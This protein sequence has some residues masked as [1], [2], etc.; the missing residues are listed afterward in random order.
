MSAS[1]HYLP[2]AVAGLLGAAVAG[3]A[4]TPARAQAEKLPV[5]CSGRGP[6]CKEIIRCEE[7]VNVTRCG[8]YET[9]YWYWYR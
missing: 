3:V 7:Y 1:R 4:L 6:L 8:T 5:D 2:W 9:I